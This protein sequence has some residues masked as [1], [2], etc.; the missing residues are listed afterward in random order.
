MHPV[1]FHILS[2]PV[3]SYGV[4]LALSFLLGLWLSSSR[5]R[6]QGLSPLV[7]AD[8]GLW[9]ILASVVGARTYYV[10]LYPER[11]EGHWT[12]AF[13]PLQG[14]A[15]GI[16][17]L[18]MYG[19]LIGAIVAGVVYFK[20]KEL[21]FLPHADAMAPSLGLG[22]MLTRFGCFLNG[23]CYGDSATGSLAIGYPLGSPAGA[24]QHQLQATGLY[25]S[26]LF[27][28]LGGLA[29]ALTILMM[30]RRTVFAGF[31]FYL[32]GILYA[33]LRFGV[34]FTRAYGASE[35]LGPLSHNQV[36][37]ICVFA[38]FAGLMVRQLARQQEAGATP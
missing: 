33:I 26:Q 8:A 19:G 15:V 34:D 1:L 12:S 36:V 9:V 27:E 11:F 6:A 4:M 24:Y 22:I 20:T 18:V 28:S 25:P 37:S 38:V 17:G 29:I 14:S 35:R 21:P 16:N 23:C 7:T 10:L 30:G 5:A 3:H 13:N 31:Q 32:V 2:F